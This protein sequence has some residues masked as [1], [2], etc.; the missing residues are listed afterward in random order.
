M[1]KTK[2][3][4][5]LTHRQTALNIVM[6]RR[7]H[8]RPPFD[9]NQAPGKT[10]FCGTTKLQ[11][12]PMPNLIPFPSRRKSPTPAVDAPTKDLSNGSALEAQDLSVLAKLLDL[13]S[14]LDEI[15]AAV[16]VLHALLPFGS[17]KSHLDRC[18]CELLLEIDRAKGRTI[19][20]VMSGL[21]QQQQTQRGEDE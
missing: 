2:A 9:V 14:R 11:T 10:H 6:W 18:R 19:R 17:S 3:K 5:S 1:T 20:L 7:M 16:E 21:V 12:L 4:F 15:A 13:T 8:R